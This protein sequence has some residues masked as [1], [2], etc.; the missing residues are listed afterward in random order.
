M[1]PYY[2]DAT[3]Q[4][5]LSSQRELLCKLQ[6]EDSLKTSNSSK[7]R[8]HQEPLLASDCM[9][10]SNLSIGFETGQKIHNTEPLSLGIGNDNFVIPDPQL[11]TEPFYDPFLE[12]ENCSKKRRKF[13]EE[14]DFDNP[15]RRRSTLGSFSQIFERCDEEAVDIAP[16]SP[17][18]DHCAPTAAA[19]TPTNSYV[20]YDDSDDDDDYGVIVETVEE[21]DCEQPL[22]SH[23][24]S[25]SKIRQR[26]VDFEHA[27]E[28]SQDSQQ[29]IHDWDRKMGLKRS[30]SKTMRLSTRSRKKLRQL[31]KKEIMHL[32][33]MC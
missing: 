20:V 8:Q 10:S 16:Q 32:S 26:L 25:H 23:H 11:D 27:M 31:L 13:H 33:K 22:P 4:S 1:A 24:H 17:I 9:N 2:N 6:F 18:R 12:E 14:D 15:K 5:L 28:R 21:P 3:F 19:T 30:H 7:K 29:K